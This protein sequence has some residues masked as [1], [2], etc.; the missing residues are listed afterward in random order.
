[1][2]SL[3]VVWQKRSKTHEITTE[4]VVIFVLN[5]NTCVSVKMP[6]TL[7]EESVQRNNDL[8]P[9]DLLLGGG[10]TVPEGHL[11]HR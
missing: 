6:L 9:G 10:H 4:T 3:I 11:S 7:L 2:S 5:I 1:M 8:V